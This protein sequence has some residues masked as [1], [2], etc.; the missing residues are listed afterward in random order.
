[1]LEVGESLISHINAHRYISG[2]NNQSCRNCK[3]YVAGECHHDTP[4]MSGTLVDWDGEEPERTVGL[5]PQ[6][7]PDD[8]C[9]QWEATDSVA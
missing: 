3:S 6:V 8:W 7:H 1:M 5:W 4:I 9:R 2:M